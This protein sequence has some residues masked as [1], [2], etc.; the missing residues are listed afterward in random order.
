MRYFFFLL[1]KLICFKFGFYIGF[2]WDIRVLPRTAPSAVSTIGPSCPATSFKQTNDIRP[3]PHGGFVNDDF[4]YETEKTKILLDSIWNHII[5]FLNIQGDPRNMTFENFFKV[6]FDIWNYL[7]HS[8]LTFILK[9]EFSFA[10]RVSNAIEF[11]LRA[12]TWLNFLN[13][14]KRPGTSDYC[15][16]CLG[17]AGGIWGCF[18]YFEFTNSWAQYWSFCTGK[19]TAVHFDIFSTFNTLQYTVHVVVHFVVHCKLCSTFWYF[20]CNVQFSLYF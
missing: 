15:V 6:V 12:I 5:E 20:R 16:L 19:Q 10:I 9:V 17:M 18:K 8:F 3:T 7:P 11:Y 14:R 13:Y 1:W 4:I 2:T